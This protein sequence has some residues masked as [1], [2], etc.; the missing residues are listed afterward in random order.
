MSDYVAAVTVLKDYLLLE[1]EFANSKK[2]RDIAE[3]YAYKSIKDV[4]VDAIS[5][6]IS[7]EISSTISKGIFEAILKEKIGIRLRRVEENFQ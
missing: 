2:K 5:S 3:G 7:R 1:S 6:A 4:S